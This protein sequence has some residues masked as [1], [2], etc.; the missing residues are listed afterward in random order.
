MA[1]LEVR[2][3]DEL[4]KKLGT[5]GTFRVLEDPMQR[6]VYRLQRDMADYPPAVPNSWYRRTGTL[7]RSWTT[8]VDRTPGWIE[9][10]IGTKLEYA[11]YVQSQE[12]QARVHRR[13][14]QTDV[15]VLDSNRSAIEADF[16]RAIQQELDK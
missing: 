9:G 12:R 10:K 14:W 5:L 4:L 15:R 16:E 7:G 11:P 6:S 3:L 1:E 2:G 13:R 8:K